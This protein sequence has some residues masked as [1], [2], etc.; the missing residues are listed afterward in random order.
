MKY[1]LFLPLEIGI[2]NCSNNIEESI[3]YC[4]NT[5]EATEYCNTT[6]ESTEWPNLPT[7]RKDSNLMEVD[8]DVSDGESPSPPPNTRIVRILSTPDL[9]SREGEAEEGPGDHQETR[10]GG[11]HTLESRVGLTQVPGSSIWET[12][13]SIIKTT[14]HPSV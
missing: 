1:P 6:E 14:N 4:N 13:R 9:E 7:T 2:E 12:L 10:E 8:D 5:E 11:D 3:E